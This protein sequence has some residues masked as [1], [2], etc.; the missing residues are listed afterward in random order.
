MNH[1]HT[2]SQAVW[3]K[4]RKGDI[5]AIHDQFISIF[6][7]HLKDKKFKQIVLRQ[8]KN[9]LRIKSA[10]SIIYIPQNDRIYYFDASNIAFSFCF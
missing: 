5:F 9:L 8:D 7:F 2:L 10:T 4:D 3:F 6:K 1:P